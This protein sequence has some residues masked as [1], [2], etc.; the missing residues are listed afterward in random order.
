MINPLP[1]IK[2]RSK[3]CRVCDPLKLS[4]NVAPILQFVPYTRQVAL[5]APV[6]PEQCSFASSASDVLDLLTHM[7][8][9]GTPRQACLHRR[10]VPTHD[11]EPVLQKGTCRESFNGNLISYD[12]SQG[13]TTTNGRIADR[14]NSLP[15]MNSSRTTILRTSNPL[16][17]PLA[18]RRTRKTWSLLTM[19]G[20]ESTEVNRS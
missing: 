11:A 8:S 3:G 14:W 1:L 15:T 4:H 5:A 18:S 9:C 2:K 20:L 12:V 10:Q 13:S 6:T 7:F 17:R 19:T 16:W